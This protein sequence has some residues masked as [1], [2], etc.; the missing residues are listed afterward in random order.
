MKSENKERGRERVRDRQR[1]IRKRVGTGERPTLGTEN[2]E[3][4]SK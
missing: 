1:L 4:G 2:Q 3:E